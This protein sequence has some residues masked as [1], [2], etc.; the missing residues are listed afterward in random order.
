MMLQGWIAKQ[1]VKL[2]GGLFLFGLAAAGFF[3]V[4]QLRSE[5]D[6]A[7]I[8]AVINRHA[9]DEAKRT[10]ARKDAQVADAEQ[11]AAA[12]EAAKSAADEKYSDLMRQ[13]ANAPHDETN[14]RLL[15]P[16]MRDAFSGLRTPAAGDP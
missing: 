13:I 3:Y 6:K 15:S 2:I 12:N 1:A 5:R 7:E 14:D 11:R 4:K 10:L 16:V 9:A 8:V